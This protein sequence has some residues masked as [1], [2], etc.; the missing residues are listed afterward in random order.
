LN[1]VGNSAVSDAVNRALALHQAGRLSE[2]E[3]LYRHVLSVDPQHFEALHFLGLIEAQRGNLEQADT[4]ISRSLEVNSTTSDAFAN[5]ARVLNSLHRPNAALAACDKALAINPGL[6]SALVSRGIALQDLGQYGQALASFDTALAIRHDYSPAWTNHGNA[7]VSLGRYQEALQSYDRAL[8]GNPR[9]A[10]A[11]TG[12]AKAL[13]LLDRIDDALASCERA[14]AIKPDHVAA[15]TYR[16]IALNLKHRPAEALASCD[17]ALAVEANLGETHFHRGNALYALGCF[18]EALA[19]QERA[20]ELGHVDAICNRA[21]VLVRLGRIEEARAGYEQALAVDPRQSNAWDG[22]ARLLLQIGSYREASAAFQKVLELNP[23]QQHARGYLVFARLQICDWHGIDE[24]CDR[25]IAAVRAGQRAATPWHLCA[26]PA[27]AADQFQCARTFMSNSP[28]MPAPPFL[29]SLG[30]AGKLRVAY[31]SPD[32]RQHPTALTFVEALEKHDRTR[33]EAIG[34][35]LAPGDGSAIR[36][37]IV[38]SFDRFYDAEREND[39]DVARRL[40]EMGVHIA[41]ELGPHTA[42][43]RA[44]ILAQRPAP[45]QVSYISAWT[46]GA[47]FVDYVIADRYCLP[48]DQQPYFVE[49]IVQ[50]PD[51]YFQND[52]TQSIS[53]QV[54]TRAESGL[55]YRG[56]VFCCFNTSYKLNPRMFDI[57]MRLLRE[58]DGSVLWLSQLNADALDNIRREAA[59]REVDPAR[60]VVATRLPSMADHLARHELA[61]LFLDTLP[62]NAHTT[63]ND[64]LRAGLPVLTCRGETFAGRVAASQLHAIAL[65][66]LVTSS[67]DEYEALA[68]GLARDPVRL[69]ELRRKLDRNR[70]NCPLFDTARLCRHLEQAYQQMWDI[71]R[72]G[73]R[74]HSFRVEPLDL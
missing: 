41:V 53:P 70:R 15:L 60:L 29:P 32:Y 65:P 46:T 67:L 33:F 48:F 17:A 52:S 68:L 28:A 49:K 40:R 13:G 24:D 1:F 23:T 8:S 61:D 3:P 45:I 12:R 2:A 25:L 58:V 21:D 16:A 43:S 55:P 72:R 36:A 66:E 74:P 69:S 19:S 47:D 63:T 56:F 31:I 18:Q 4:L 51:S 35:S 73:E 11:L 39:A 7:L 10:A 71:Y 27:T 14:I 38:E 26:V 59:A 44:G 54:P 22:L 30:N 5:H 64:A 9:D 42:G 6:L 57:W 50:L 62:Y 34:V 37:R 20:I